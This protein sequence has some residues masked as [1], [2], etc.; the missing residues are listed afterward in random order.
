MVT[1]RD[2]TGRRGSTR[3]FAGH[4]AGQPLPTQPTNSADLLGGLTRP[5]AYQ[6][7]AVPVCRGVELT[8]PTIRTAPSPSGPGRR[9]HPDAIP[10]T[11]H[12]TSV[13]TRG[14]QRKLSAAG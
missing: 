2:H 3:L 8:Q 6:V 11:Y 13:Q 14:A 10:V 5:V 9:R 12:P 1:T 7:G 4:L